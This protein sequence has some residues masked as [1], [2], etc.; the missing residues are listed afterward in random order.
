MNFV[1]IIVNIVSVD[2]SNMNWHIQTQPKLKKNVSSLT[3]CIHWSYSFKP[4][5]AHDLASL[6]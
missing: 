3:I 6:G 2:T 5:G 4:G 1:K